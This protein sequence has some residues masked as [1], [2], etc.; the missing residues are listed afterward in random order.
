MYNLYQLMRADFLERTRRYSFLITLGLVL[1]LGYLCVDGTLTLRL[2][3]YRGVFN[4]AWVGAMMALVVNTF[5]GL[6]G[7]YVVKGAV[8]RDRQTGVGQII[9]TTPLTRLQY[10]LG[11]WLSNFAVL[12]T[13]V[14]VLAVVALGLQFFQAEDD[15]LNLW[16]LL[17]P[18]LLVSLPFMAFIAALA[19][20]FDVVPFLRGGAGNVIYFFTWNA[21][22]IFSITVLS[23]ISP[24]FDPTGMG[25]YWSDMRVALLKVYPA[26]A[27]G[28]SLGS[29]M[30]GQALTF[31]WP[32]LNW[33]PAMLAARVSFVLAAV[34]VVALAALMF[35]R[36]VV[37]PK[38]KA[39]KTTAQP[40]ETKK[41]NRASALASALHRPLTPVTARF[42]FFTVVWAELKLALKGQRWWWYAV[43]GILLVMPLAADSD[44]LSVLGGF[45]YIWPLL[46]WSALGNREARWG[47]HQLVFAAPQP[48]VRQLPATWLVGVAVTALATLGVGANLLFT[49]ALDSFFTWSMGVLFIPTLA[50][51]LG[52]WSGSSKAFEVVYVMLWYA[53]P[54]NSIA[55]L[56][57]INGP[58]S[59]GITL[60]IATTALLAA[61]VLGRQKQL[62]F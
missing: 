39:S 35:D 21:I 49:G 24:A 60:A 53:G 20:L 34:G 2:D 17:S 7:F 27:G 18:F 37:A 16:A 32:G 33:T 31:V 61:A 58:A 54:L 11:K 19:V 8:E 55:Q 50:L 42:S 22:L 48:L 36:F 28:F 46:I 45:T 29:P 26:Y 4:S 62:R 6:F 13:M 23:Q 40:D 5:L 25:L 3:D 41:A 47:T 9:A 12:G 52:V 56:N 30:P 15:A 59:T 51:A 10:L 57:F 44:M 43:A 1:W 38:V 14:A